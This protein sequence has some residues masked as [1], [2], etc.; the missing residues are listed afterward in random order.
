MQEILGRG[1]EAEVL[2]PQSIRDQF[3]DIIKNLNSK[4]NG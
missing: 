2:S 3:A 4:Y 1:D